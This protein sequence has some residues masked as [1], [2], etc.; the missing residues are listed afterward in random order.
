MSL[1]IGH[2]DSDTFWEALHG[3]FYD[4]LVRLALD[5]SGS[6]AAR[7]ADIKTKIGCHIFHATGITDY[8]KNGGRLEIAQQMA[9][10]E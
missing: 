3:L 4:S 5:A 1:L 8:L 7:P 2:V 9:N 10:H 6:R